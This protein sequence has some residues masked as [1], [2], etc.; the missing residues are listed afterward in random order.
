MLKNIFRGT[1]Y[2]LRSKSILEKTDFI[3]SIEKNPYLM[4]RGKVL[5]DI[6]Q[7]KIKT[8]Q[9]KHLNHNFCSQ[10]FRWYVVYRG[11]INSKTRS[12]D[13]KFT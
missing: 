8:N 7:T 5:Q 3:Q 1:W 6:Y 2:D 9:T 4:S 12:G 13:E 11:E 10:I